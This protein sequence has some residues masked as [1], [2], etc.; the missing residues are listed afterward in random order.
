MKHRP[1]ID[2]LRAVA[3]IPVVLFHAGIRHVAGG[4]IGV[5]VFFVI[6][7]FLITGI[8]MEDIR[9]DRFSIANFYERRARRILPALFTVLLF[10]TLLKAGPSGSPTAQMFLSK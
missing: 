2:G 3:V 5:D 1:D 10:A 6:S 4:Y 9:Q 8:L 7:G